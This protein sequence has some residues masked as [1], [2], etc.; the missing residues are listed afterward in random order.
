MAGNIEPME[1]GRRPYGVR[2][3]VGQLSDGCSWGHVHLLLY[4]LDAPAMSADV[5][6]VLR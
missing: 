1:A 5:A 2:G 3:Q 6:F 4:P